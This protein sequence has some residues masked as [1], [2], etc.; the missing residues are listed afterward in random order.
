MA[1][2]HSTKLV[3]NPKNKGASSDGP[4]GDRDGGYQGASLTGH[5]PVLQSS[6]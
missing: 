5:Y 1:I 3:R 4:L 2:L 6:V